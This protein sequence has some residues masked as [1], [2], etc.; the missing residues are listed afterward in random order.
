MINLLFLYTDSMTPYGMTVLDVLDNFKMK[1]TF[2][3]WLREIG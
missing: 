2:G 3:Y 1:T